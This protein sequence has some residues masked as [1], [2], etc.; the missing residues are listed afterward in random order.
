MRLAECHLR[1]T[2]AHLTLTHLAT[3]GAPIPN[4]HRQIHCHGVPEI[5]QHA[6][7]GIRRRRAVQRELVRLDAVERVDD[8]ARVE[9]AFR[10]PDV[11]VRRGE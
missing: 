4:R 3:H 1:L 2:L 7:L 5:R 8:D 6:K 9:R 11:R 10:E